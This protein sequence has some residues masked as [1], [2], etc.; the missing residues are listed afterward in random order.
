MKTR[1][2]LDPELLRIAEQ[3]AVT[4]GTNVDAVIEDALRAHLAPGDKRPTTFKLNIPI[5]SGTRR[6]AVDVG[7]RDALYGL[8]ERD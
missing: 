1:V 7:S 6:P 8:R 3:R 4:T 5:V 2:E